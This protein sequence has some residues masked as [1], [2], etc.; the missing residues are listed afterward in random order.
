MSNAKDPLSPPLNVANIKN[1]RGVKSL[2]KR[3]LD[4]HG[5]FSWC[6][7][8]N[9]YG[10]HGVHDFNALKNGVFI[11]IETKFETRKATVM[12]KSFAAHIMTENGFSFLVNDRNIDH[13]AWWL[14]S[15]EAATLEAV[16][17]GEVPQEHG[18]RMLN[19]ISV[20]TD[21]FA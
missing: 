11:T 7:P 1:E 9:G 2:V 20:L 3:L 14:E 12:Q 19:A 13:L 17:G 18:A 16:K 21:G 4:R 8:A 10:T 5:W 15:M 6:P